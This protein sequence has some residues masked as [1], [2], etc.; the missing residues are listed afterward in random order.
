MPRSKTAVVLAPGH[1]G[2]MD[3]L[4]AFVVLAVVAGAVWQ[5][6]PVEPCA[7]GDESEA[8]DW[9]E[10]STAAPLISW[11]S[12][13]CRLLR[14]RLG[15][16]QL[17]SDPANASDAYPAGT[18]L[19]DVLSELAGLGFTGQFVIDD[20]DGSCTCTSCGAP[21]SPGSV[22]FEQR[23]RLEGAS[24]PADMANV[25]AI[26]CPRCAAPGVVVCR[27][28]PEASSGDV[29]LLQAARGQ[30]DS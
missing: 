12:G 11:T 7:G 8:E 9:L 24:D 27:F 13:R 23:R 30:L 21:S 3:T 22:R 16:V 26:T 2:E 5:W 18:S 29:A 14:G 15:K 1:G 17:M 4:V 28:G 20:D 6:A 19:A 25:L 10:D